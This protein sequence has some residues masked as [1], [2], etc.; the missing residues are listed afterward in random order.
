MAV[1]REE[2]DTVRG[3]MF[4]NDD[5]AVIE[6]GA[7]IGKGVDCGV[8]GRGDGSTGRSK[9]IEAEVDG[10]AL[11]RGILTRGENLGR[12]KGARLVVAADGNGDVSSAQ[13]RLNSRGCDR[14]GESGRIGAKERAA[15]AE[16]EGRAIPFPKI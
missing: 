14:F 11:V 7:I 8:E 4:E 13:E 15:D 9:E 3:L 16:I 5:W 6:G 2:W 10:A 1:E 12:V